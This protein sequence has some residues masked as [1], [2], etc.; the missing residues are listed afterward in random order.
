[1]RETKARALFDDF[2]EM[3]DFTLQVLNDLSGFFFFLL[4]L[5]NKA[6]RFV[7]FFF[8]HT[9]CV[10]ILLGKLDGSFYSGCV[11]SERVSELFASL[12]E[13]LLAFVGSFEGA[14]E[15][16]VLRLKTLH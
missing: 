12:D 14:M 13:A 8:Q 7:N 16:F 5:F 10:A 2:V 9:D 3:S 6:P 15:F 1:M 11:G 4:S